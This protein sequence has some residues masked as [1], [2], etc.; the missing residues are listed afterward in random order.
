MEKVAYHP[1]VT[2]LA[3]D[4]PA[5]DLPGSLDDEQAT[6]ALAD[7]KDRGA[8]SQHLVPGANGD[9]LQQAVR[10]EDP[11][12]QAGVLSAAA[13]ESALNPSGGIVRID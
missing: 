10:T 12:V 2:P 6:E 3:I 7:L 1:A 4:Q 11:L 9:R 5:G 8:V 13:A